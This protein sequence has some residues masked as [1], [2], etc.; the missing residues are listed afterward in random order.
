MLDLIDIAE[1]NGW[2][3][4][5]DFTSLKPKIKIETKNQVVYSL[6]S[7][8]DQKLAE[9]LTFMEALELVEKHQF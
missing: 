2:V 5:F 3:L 8:D 4:S 9:I 1:T 7:G 6:V